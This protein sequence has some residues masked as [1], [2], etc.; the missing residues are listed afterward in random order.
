MTDLTLPKLPSFCYCLANNKCYV[1]T[2]HNVLK[3]SKKDPSKKI[4][5]KENVKNVGIIDSP[6]GIGVINFYPQFIS[7]NPDLS[8]ERFTICRIF[9][10][11]S[12]K[13]VLQITPSKA[14]DK[15]K[16]PRDINVIQYA[17]HLVVSTILKTDPLVAS[18]KTIF[19]EQWQDCLALAEFMVA[20]P[21]AKMADFELFS[22]NH[23]T[24][25]EGHMDGP[26]ISRLFKKITEEKICQFFAEYFARLEK[27]LFYNK[28]RFWALDSTNFGCYGKSLNDIAWGHQKQDEEL[29]QLNVMMLV[30]QETQRPLFYMHFNGSVPDV[31]TVHTMCDYAI[32]LGARSFVLVFDRG[33]YGK[34]NIGEIVD[35]GYHFVSCVP[36][37]K[38]VQFNEEIKQ[39]AAQLLSGSCYSKYTGQSAVCLDKDFKLSDGRQCKL[40]VHVFYSPETAGVT[41][42][43]LLRRRADVEELIKNNKQLDPANEKFAKAYLK[44]GKDGTVSYNN[45]AFQE[46]ANRAGSF[47]IISDTVKNSSAAYRAY[48]ARKA[49]EEVFSSL[50]SR[51]QMRRVRVSTEESLDGKCFIQF[52]AVSIWM[53]LDHR[54]DKLRADDKQVPH[55]SLPHVIKELLSLKCIIFDG[56][57]YQYLNISKKQRECLGIFGVS[58]PQSGY[59]DNVPMANRVVRAGKPHAFS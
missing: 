43:N 33:Y 15:I 39:T 50:K 12:D 31:S 56:N 52:L 5:V 27:D 54:L 57:Y 48:A 45:A 13:P 51:M 19:P 36:L 9:H 46:A 1:R 30:D 37:H 6:D 4:A 38:T 11:S 3:P 7:A 53:M 55:N 21:D 40:Y 22:Q 44:V 10:E 42:E 8:L 49:V 35:S 32:R 58:L 20:Q 24:Y 17:L 23:T 26:A 59:N 34:D 2:Y 18:L 47:V 28:E 29:P 16:Y 41:V 25:S 14:E